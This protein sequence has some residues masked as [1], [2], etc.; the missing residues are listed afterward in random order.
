MAN[1]IRYRNINKYVLE[2]NVYI[3]TFEEITFLGTKEFDIVAI[4]E[5]EEIKEIKEGN[6]LVFGE[7]LELEEFEKINVN[8]EISKLIN[9]L[10]EVFHK[11]EKAICV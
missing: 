4:I 8:F 7:W 9:E 2:E 1:K 11:K 10:N 3:I 6:V 5:D